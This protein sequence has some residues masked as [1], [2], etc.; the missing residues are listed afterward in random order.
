MKLS[1]VI[2]FIFTLLGFAIFMTGFHGIDTA[3]N[4]K[5]IGSASDINYFGRVID[6]NTLYMQSVA[7]TLFG[8]FLGMVSAAVLEVRSDA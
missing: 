1:V 8:F 2:P 6:A 7:M 5:N 3:W 4:M